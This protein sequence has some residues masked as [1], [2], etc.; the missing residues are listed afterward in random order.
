MANG[1]RPGL[2]IDRLKGH[3]GYE[4]GNCEWVTLSE[5]VRRMHAARKAAA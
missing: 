3:L 5:N 4:P 1:Y 2:S